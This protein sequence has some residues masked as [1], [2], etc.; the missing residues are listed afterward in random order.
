MLLT[1]HCSLL[2]VWWMFGT[3]R[4]V[5]GGGRISIAKEIGQRMVTQPSNPSINQAQV[6]H[7]FND[8]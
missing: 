3:K 2:T 4:F 8:R 1:A 7:P 5:D 6:E